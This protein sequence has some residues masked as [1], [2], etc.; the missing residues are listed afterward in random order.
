MTPGK[1]RGLDTLATDEGVFAILAIDHRDSLRVV[2][3]GEAADADIVQFKLDLLSGVG[4]TASGAMLEPEFSIPQAVEAGAISGNTGSVAVARPVSSADA[5][6][7]TLNVDPGGKTSRCAR[8]S[9]GT[10][11]SSSRASLASLPSSASPP[12]SGVSVER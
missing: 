8:V 6:V 11:G 9:S 12:A 7:T 2:L 4:S 1:M 5:A 3:P 10:D